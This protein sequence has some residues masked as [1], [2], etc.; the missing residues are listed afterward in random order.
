M[1]IM[2]VLEVQAGTLRKNQA[3][4]KR[5]INPEYDEFQSKIDK[6][7][8]ERAAAYKKLSERWREGD[9]KAGGPRKNNAEGQSAQ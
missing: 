5:G 3:K 2:N 4:Y 1:Q 8:E 7:E 6:I 9:L